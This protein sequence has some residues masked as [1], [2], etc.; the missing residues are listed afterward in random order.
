MTG[1]SLI[2]RPSAVV[3]NYCSKTIFEGY[4][5]FS[6][7]ISMPRSELRWAKCV[8]VLETKPG[9]IEKTGNGLKYYSRY[10]S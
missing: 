7:E 9:K 3:T 5:W 8:L 10:D 2:S 4:K 6:S 1:R